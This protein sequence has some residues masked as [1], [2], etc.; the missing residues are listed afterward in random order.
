[1]GAQ[2]PPAPLLRAGLGRDGAHPQAQPAQTA[3]GGPGRGGLRPRHQNPRRVG[4]FYVRPLLAHIE[5]TDGIIDQIVYQLYGPTEE[6]I[7][8]VEGPSV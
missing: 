3:P 2:G 4:D 6:E 8:V 1:M 7:A 5:A